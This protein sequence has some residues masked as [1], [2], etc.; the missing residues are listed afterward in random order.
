MAVAASAGAE[1]ATRPVTASDCVKVHYLY[2][3]YGAP[4]ITVNP[5]GTYAAYLVKAPNLDTN[6]NDIELYVRALPGGQNETSRR[7]STDVAFSQMHWLRDGRHL[8]LLMRQNAHIAVGSIDTET[9][10]R[11]V[12]ASTDSDIEEYSIDR[13]GNTLVY[14]TDVPAQELH[15]HSEE[16]IRRGYRIPNEGNPAAGQVHQ[17]MFQ[18]KNLFLVRRLPDGKWSSPEQ[19]SLRHPLTGKLETRILCTDRFALSLSPDGRK[20]LMTLP[21][22]DLRADLDTSNWPKNWLDSPNIQNHLTQGTPLM[23]PALLDL[24]SRRVSIPMETPY[25]DSGALWAPDGQSLL[26]SAM[27]PV[28]SSWEDQDRKA[29][30]ASHYPFHL[31][32]VN[33]GNGLVQQVLPG[34][35][36]ELLSYDGHRVLLSTA[37]RTIEILENIKGAAWGKIS[38]FRIPVEDF[39]GDSGLAVSG[40]YLLAGYQNTTTP[41]EIILYKH[42]DHQVQVIDRLNPEFDHLTLAPSRLVSWQT[43]EG[44]LMEGLLILPTSYVSGQRYPLVIQ[45]KAGRGQFLCDGG[46]Y[47]MPSFA[48]QPLANDG[49]AYLVSLGGDDSSAYPKGY[50]GGIAEAVFYSDVWDS[51][52]SSLYKD[53][54]IDKNKVGIIGFSRTGWSVE[55]ALSHAATQY[56]AATVADNVQY[57][58]AEYWFDHSNVYARGADA[59]YGGPPYGST[60]KNWMQYSPSFNLEKI[61]TPLLMEAM[62]YGVREDRAGSTPFNLIPRYEALIGLTRLGKPVEM[63]YYPDEDHEPNHPQARLASLQRNI[64]WYRFWLQGYERPNPQDPD[65]YKRWEYLRELQGA[66]DKATA[67]SEERATVPIKGDIC[68]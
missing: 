7:L 28:G 26:M 31:W 54:I 24:D 53:G 17:S 65:Q 35:V 62:G 58:F 56:K 46:E 23:I 6:Q 10:A 43:P 45:T 48:P 38:E 22:L 61:H 59:M 2:R 12:L 52:V 42:G 34:S 4:S 19:L 64:D 21:G 32:H 60:L 5:Q 30:I 41:P 33:L 1:Q 3:D 44:K 39:H 8:A 15:P 29:G 9:G 68:K 14:T 25:V 16:E 50:P 63:Y 67:K 11:E 36:Q 47:H 18:E 55:Y 66:D 27:S 13:D 57:T 40:D 20:L 37:D 49:I 51:A